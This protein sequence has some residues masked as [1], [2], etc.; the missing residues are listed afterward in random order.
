MSNTTNQT[1]CKLPQSQKLSLSHISISSNQPGA[2][3]KDVEKLYTE[4]SETTL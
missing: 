2:G 1:G 3:H 4:M